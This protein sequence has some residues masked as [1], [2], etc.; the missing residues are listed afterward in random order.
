MDIEGKLA[1]GKAWKIRRGVPQQN[2]NPTQSPKIESETM[3]RV[4]PLMKIFPLR[5]LVLGAPFAT[6]QSFWI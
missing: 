4:F 3:K 2:K 6:H 1:S 5:Y